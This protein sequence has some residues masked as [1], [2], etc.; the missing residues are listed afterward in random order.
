[1]GRAEL[2]LVPAAVAI[3][4][5]AILGTLAGTGAAL[6]AGVLLLVGVLTALLTGAGTTW[7]GPLTAHLTLVLLAATL[8][9]PAL[10]RQES[11][12]DA[13]ASASG[14][15]VELAVRLASEPEAPSSGPA[16]A[17]TGLQARARTLRGPAELGAEQTVLR[18][19]VPVL[20]RAEDAGAEGLFGVGDGQVVIVRGTLRDADGLLVLQGRAVAPAATSGPAGAAQDL[21]QR[22]RLGFRDRTA[23]LPADEAALLRGMTTGDTHGLGEDSEQAMRRA[24]I[25]HLVAVSGANIAL[26]IAAVLVP[27]LLLGVRRRPRLLAAIVLAGAYVALVG[28]EPSVQRAATM[29]LPLLLARLAGVRASPVACLAAAVALWSVLDPVTAA[30]VGFLLSALSTGA[31]LLAAPP[32]A[33][34]LHAA[35]GQRL[36]VPAAL[37]LAVPLVAQ[38]V[39]TPV[40]ILLA[41]EVS[42][43]T[44]AVNMAVAPLVGPTTVLGIL[45]LA[46]GLAWPAA[47]ALLAQIGAGGAHLVLLT[48]HT[49]DALPGSRVPVPAGAT[50]AL[51]AVGILAAL[52]VALALR[53][54]RP[55]RWATAALLVALLAPP[56]V[57]LLPGTTDDSWRIAACAVGQGDAMVLRGSGP[58]PPTVLVD[59]G[60]DPA[61]LTRCLDLLEVYRIDLLILSHPHAD[62]TGGAEALRGRRIPAAQWVCPLPEA[63]TQAAPEPAPE[64]VL[65][66]D[67]WAGE[68]LDLEVLWPP[69]LAA[70]EQ[71]AR[72][73]ADTGEQDAANDCS[74]TLAATWADGT[75]LVALGDLEPAAQAVLAELDPGPVDVVKV[76]HHGSRF[77]E[78]VLY[79]SL[80]ARTA[81][82]TVGQDNTFGHPTPELLGMLAQQNTAVLRTDRD[83]T[84]VLGPG[85]EPEA[86][87]VGP[88]R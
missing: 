72:L 71:A 19:A 36:P 55:V 54:R 1:M 45:A 22:L 69:D 44:V 85:P 13:L 66:G 33:R 8:L 10:H 73:D 25:S 28:D 46:A 11:A 20:L 21:R 88:P 4:T 80:D 37:V 83:G 14:S 42:L 52:A 68:G 79:E 67:S 51:T 23:G 2:R 18:A 29:A 17:R 5:L 65:R 61:L 57:R 84:V 47:G 75:R 24:G 43:W 78:H 30:S 58:D 26:V 40:L 3:W 60:P 6:A 49:A 48:A 41:P 64:T 81:L 27:L 82:V 38:L 86:R 34:A 50:G 87:S 77:Q 15:T 53:H 12:R 63:G 32:L 7:R 76:A 62:H 74:I 56:A 9:M 16:W 31:I 59:T 35:T 39:C 70:I